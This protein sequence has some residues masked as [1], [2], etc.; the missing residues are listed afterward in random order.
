MLIR[1]VCIGQ[2]FVLFTALSRRFIC[3]SRSDRLVRLSL[4]ALYPKAMRIIHTFA[5]MGRHRCLYRVFLQEAVESL[6]EYE[7]NDWSSYS[8][9]CQSIPVR[10]R[11]K[12]ERTFLEQ[13]SSSPAL[14]FH[15]PCSFQVSTFGSH[16][17]CSPS[18]R[19]GSEDLIL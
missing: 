6:H 3:C 2:F 8:L 12:V 9:F 16:F 17:Y 11:A 10:R 14:I 15:S 4:L 13:A 19:M 5:I 18:V 7:A 1:V